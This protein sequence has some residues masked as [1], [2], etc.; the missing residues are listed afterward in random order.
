MRDFVF[1]LI[2]VRLDEGGFAVA[3]FLGTGFFIGRRNVGLTAAHV[4]RNFTQAAALIATDDGWRAFAATAPEAH[5]SEDVAVFELD[6]PT[7]RAAWISVCN[8]VSVK[9]L[10]GMQYNLLGYPEDAYYEVVADGQPYPRPDMI[11]SEGHVRR[12]LRG[13]PL[14]PMTGDVFMELSQVA[15]AGCSGSPVFWRRGAM[16]SLAGV[17]VGERTN[18]RATSVGYAVPSDAF[19][20]WIPDLLGRALAEELADVER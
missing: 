9:P 6:P 10:S 11:Y 5:P 16:G 14:P 8:G 13:V 19:A 2:N 12:R 1:P 17:Y 3:G 7:T 18:D 4:S 15:G 20:D